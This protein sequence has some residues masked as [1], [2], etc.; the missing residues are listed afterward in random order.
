V[1]IL[2]HI[3]I[4]DMLERHEQKQALATLAV[5]KRRTSRYFLFDSQ[6]RLC[7]WESVTTGEKKIAVSQAGELQRF[8]FMGVHLI[9]PRIFPLLPS[10][11]AFSI[12]PTYLKLAGQGE[13]ILGFPSNDSKWLDVGKPE[14]LKLA[15]DFLAD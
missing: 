12:V 2:T 7:G 13:L 1:D 6:N 15:A 9:S 14:T 10:E 4:P 5:R 11:G 3:N 8:S